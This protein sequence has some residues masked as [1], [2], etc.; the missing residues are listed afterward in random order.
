MESIS[1]LYLEDSPT[2]AELTLTILAGAGV[3]HVANRVDTEEEFVAELQ[4]GC[5]DL[6]LSD[7]ALP[8][9]DGAAALELAQQ[10]CPEIPFIFVSGAIGEEVAI[11]SLQRGA[12]DYVLKYRLKRLVPAVRRAMAEA[13]QRKARKLAEERQALFE[14]EQA[15]RAE[16][17][18]QARQ[19][20][21]VN[22]KLEQFAVAA[23]HDLQEPL[24]TVKG[25]AGLLSRRYRPVLE[26]N[27]VEFIDYIEQGVARMERV[28]Y[29]LLAY[30]RMVHDQREPGPVDLELVVRQTLEIL[31]HSIEESGATITV[32]PLPTV[33]A[34]RERIASVF[35]NLLSNSLKYRRGSSPEI[36]VSAQRSAGEWILSVR[37]NG[38]GFRPEDAH[39]LFGLFK[40]L[41]GDGYPGTGVG[42]ALVK[43][44]VEQHGGRIWAESLPGEGATFYF[45]LPASEGSPLVEENSAAPEI[46]VGVG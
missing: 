14:K 8:S 15:A 10:H 43:Q 4:A 23:S 41:H 26:G 17:E 18:A 39:R 37:D 5:Y 44:I 11:D 16:A 36:R 38:I 42:L 6:I 33:L 34:D 9:F 35:Q 21:H 12:T 29:S 28:I 27:G 31:R 32:G 30:S 1:I 22:A 24:R 13:E 46:G 20:A 40:R 19:L 3:E 25:Y 45:T 2:D 7:Y